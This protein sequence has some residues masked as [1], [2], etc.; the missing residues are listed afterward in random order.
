[1]WQTLHIYMSTFYVCQSGLHTITTCVDVCVCE[2]VQMWT[3]DLR[4]RYLFDCVYMHRTRTPPQT[5]GSLSY[6]PAIIVVQRIS[7]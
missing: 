1:M 3:K 7:K 2:S 5:A 4:S 6:D